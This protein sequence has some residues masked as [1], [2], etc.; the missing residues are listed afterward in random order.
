[1]WAKTDQGMDF[2]AWN[3]GQPDNGA[4]EDEDCLTML[5]GNYS[6]RRLW[7]DEDCTL[8]HGKPLCQIFPV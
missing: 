8:V 2:S 3:E 1:M 4:N 6:E 5:P 7:N